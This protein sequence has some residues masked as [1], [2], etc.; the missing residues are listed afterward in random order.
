MNFL[1][2][3][4]FRGTTNPIFLY[5]FSPEMLFMSKS[6]TMFVKLLNHNT[7]FEG[8]KAQKLVNTLLYKNTLVV[9]LI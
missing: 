6:I 3:Q 8:L 7:E 4:I 5:T 9:V 2:N 1:L